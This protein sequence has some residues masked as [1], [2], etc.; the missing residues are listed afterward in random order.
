MNFKMYGLHKRQY[1]RVK[2]VTHCTIIVKKASI[3]TTVLSCY[4]RT[5]NKLN[6][7]NKK[8]ILAWLM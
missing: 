4:Y 6:K 8:V 7:Q 3:K 5:N 2:K 1:I